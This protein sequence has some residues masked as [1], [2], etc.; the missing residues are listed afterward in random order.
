MKEYW[1]LPEA[2]AK[3]FPLG[4]DSGWFDTGGRWREWDSRRCGCRQVLAPWGRIA[5]GRHLVSG[6]KG[7]DSK[8]LGAPSCV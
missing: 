8:R 4:R 5:A 3:A 1:K 6:W 2:T 7:G